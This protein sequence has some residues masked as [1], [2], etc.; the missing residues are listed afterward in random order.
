MTTDAAPDIEELVAQLEANGRDAAALVAGLDEAT[1][2]RP[3]APGAWSVSEC[4]DHLAT[5]DR[6]YLEALRPAAARGRERGRRRRGP[7]R[8]G[9][10]GRWFARSLEPNAGLRSRAP[11]NIRPRVAPPL[12]D[13][14]AAF[15]TA[16]ADV[17]DFLRENADLDLAGI[18]FVNPFVRGVRFSLATGLHVIAA[19][20][21][22]HLV[23]GWNA[24]R[25]VSPA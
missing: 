4:L 6:V 15:Q 24:R 13:S 25:A 23:Q 20:E 16:H 7:A 9:I 18:T 19:H 21:R 1:G 12:A 17:L 8:P 10:I 2:T 22:R 14:A 3:P 11:R 5:A